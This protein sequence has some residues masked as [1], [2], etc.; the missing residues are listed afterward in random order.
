MKK[1]IEGLEKRLNK[2]FDYYCEV[3]RSTKSE[4]LIY[5]TINGCTFRCLVPF[6]EFKD[7][8]SLSDD[9]LFN[10]VSDELHFELI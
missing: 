2:I 8:V 9:E 1:T 10:Y 4:F 7:I 3:Y 5:K 6:N